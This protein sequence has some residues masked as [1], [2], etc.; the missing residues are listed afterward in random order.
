MNQAI[1]QADAG[2]DI[3]DVNVGV[4]SVNEA[5]VLPE[6]VK[7]IQSVTGLPLQIDSSDPAA[8]EA[9][10]RVYNGKAIVNSVNGD[11]EV[12]ER[13]L[14][15]VAKYG[16]A[17]IGLTLDGD[18]IPNT[19]EGRIAIAERILKKAVEYGIPEEDVIIDCLAL[20]ASAQQAKLMRPSEP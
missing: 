3:L 17:V 13:I 12:M 1:E 15:V 20:T 19:A 18:G 8:I 7:K 2:A 5:E 9:A 6:V 16:A 4:P 11:E 14:P 10:L